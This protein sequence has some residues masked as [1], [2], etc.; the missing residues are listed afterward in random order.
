M[1]FGGQLVLPID[2]SKIDTEMTV[3]LCR[4]QIYNEILQ[5]TEKREKEEEEIS[6]VRRLSSSS[7]V[8]KMVTTKAQLKKPEEDKKCTVMWI[9][10]L[11][12]HL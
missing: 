3:R 6:L 4:T 9:V 8:L 10:C 11:T 12:N 7:K 2:F 5:F 1:P